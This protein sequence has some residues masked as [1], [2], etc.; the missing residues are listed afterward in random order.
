[1][2]APAATREMEVA[3]TAGSLGL[4]HGHRMLNW[5]PLNFVIWTHV[6]RLEISFVFLS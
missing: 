4:G 6:D 3:A 5:C 2:S 1:M